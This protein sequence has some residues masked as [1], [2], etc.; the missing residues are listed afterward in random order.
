ML[1]CQTSASSVRFVDYGELAARVDQN[2]TVP[3]GCSPASPALITLLSSLAGDNLLLKWQVL[4]DMLICSERLVAL[5]GGLEVVCRAK[6]F[7]LDAVRLA[8]RLQVTRW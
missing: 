4:A 2:P 8:V 3:P 1:G 7:C 5:L 6:A